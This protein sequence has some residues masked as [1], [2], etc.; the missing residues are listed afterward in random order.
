MAAGAVEKKA[1]HLLAKSLVLAPERAPHYFDIA[2]IFTQ[3]AITMHA[4]ANP[5][6]LTLG[7]PNGLGPELA[8]RLLGARDGEPPVYRPKAPLLMVGP[9]SSLLP[10][11]ERL[12]FRP[13][14]TPLAHPEDIMGKGQGIY[15][16]EPT[17][18]N[19]FPLAPGKA[20][21]DGGYAAGISLELAS[22]LCLGGSAAGMVTLPLH[23]GML[24]AAGFPFA[25][26]TEFLARRSFMRDEDVC[27][28]LC[29]DVLR[30]SL[31]TTHPPLH[32]VPKLVRKEKVLH[33][34]QLTHDFLVQL[35]LGRQAIAV[36]GLN[37]HAGEGGAIGSEDGE[38]IAP[39]VREAREEGLDV[40]GPL[41][42]DSVFYRA[43]QGEFDA[44]L[45]M[46]H[47]QG[48]APLKL[49]HFNRAVN[50]TLGLPYVRT[51]VDHGTGHDIVGQ[52]TATTSSLEAALKLAHTLT[53][54]NQ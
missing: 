15:F 29:G 36:C 45:A 14:W 41:P 4:Y 13:F 26:H 33:F 51:S 16:H 38:H 54:A 8:C 24:L 49:L 28:H 12:G 22:R 27:M 40:H 31:L 43:A 48:L 42:G 39:A 20:T 52:D 34:L 50:V 9:G 25:G 11:L 5:L 46:Y 23:K 6:V 3:Y 37:P 19:N 1:E 30:V 2:T 35:G 10:H 47:D 32:R 44:V 7:D 53:N 18:L 17:E 21:K